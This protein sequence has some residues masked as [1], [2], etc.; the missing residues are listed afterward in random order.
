M[1]NKDELL[2]TLDTILVARQDVLDRLTGEDIATFKSKASVAQKDDLL[3]FS[4]ANQ[5]TILKELN[6]VELQ[7][8]KTELEK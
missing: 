8:L 2:R 4:D 1:T 3:T 6:V 7:A 5:Q